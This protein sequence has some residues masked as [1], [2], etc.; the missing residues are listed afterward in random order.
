MEPLSAWQ[1]ASH[2]AR[3]PRSVVGMQH[4]HPPGCSTNRLRGSRP[5]VPG[6]RPSAPGVLSTRALASALASPSRCASN[7]RFLYALRTLSWTECPFPPH[8]TPQI[9]RWKCNPQCD[10]R[11][12]LRQEGEPQEGAPRSR[13]QSLPPWRTRYTVR[14]RPGGRV[15]AAQAPCGTLASRPPG[16]RAKRLACVSAQPVVRGDSSSLSK[17]PLQHPV[18]LTP[19]VPA[20]WGWG[21]SLP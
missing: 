13:G 12:G 20:G 7:G 11:G 6:W 8:P 5:P 16:L 15:A 2:V 19:R 21:W 18:P 9:H 1:F 4:Y 17:D 3:S 10:R 14:G